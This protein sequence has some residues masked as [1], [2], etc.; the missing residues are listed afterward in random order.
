MNKNINSPKLNKL[1]ANLYNVKCSDKK[2]RIFLKNLT[3]KKLSKVIL[4]LS[5]QGTKIANI[6]LK[7]IKSTINNIRS[8]NIHINKMNISQINVDQGRSIKKIMTRS[9]GR[10]N[11]IR[12][13]SSNISILITY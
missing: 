6:I 10:M 5:V 4:I 7:M 9:Q 8:K 1:T 3:G 11:Y 13:R 12:K 2:I